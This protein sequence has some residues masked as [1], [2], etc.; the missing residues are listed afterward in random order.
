[1]VVLV[2]QCMCSVCMYVVYIFLIKRTLNLRL[3]SLRQFRPL[4]NISLLEFFLYYSV[5]STLHPNV[6]CSLYITTPF[7]GWSNF[8]SFTFSCSL[9]LIFQYPCYLLFEAYDLPPLI[10][11]ITFSFSVCQ[12]QFIDVSV[13]VPQVITGNKH[14]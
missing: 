5:L 1:M 10:P 9:I 6:C 3:R 14:C 2:D 8:A 7:N 12:L 11:G 13:S 4:L